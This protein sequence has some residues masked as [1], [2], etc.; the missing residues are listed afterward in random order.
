MILPLITLKKGIH[1]QLLYHLNQKV[2]NAMDEIQSVK[3]SI[4]NETKSSAGDKYETGR[5][6]MQ[7]EIDLSQAEIDKARTMLSEL[8]AIDPEKASNRI[9]K[10][11]LVKTNQGN[12]YI[13][14][15]IGK[16]HLDDTECY[17]ISLHSPLGLLL[18]GKSPG[19][20][21]ILS[22]REYHIQEIA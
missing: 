22:E 12:Y 17:C 9:T 5:A 19:E 3:A 18:K 4:S 7:Q 2:T 8:S 1:N 15:G 21:V 11:S 13:S 10:G 20:T 14:V 16:I 6:M